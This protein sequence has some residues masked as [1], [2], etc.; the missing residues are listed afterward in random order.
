MAHGHDV[1]TYQ[2]PYG[3][4]EDHRRTT[5]CLACAER[6]EM[7]HGGYT[8][9]T[10]LRRG[11]CQRQIEADPDHAADLAE[12]QAQY[13]DLLDAGLLGERSDQWTE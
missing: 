1:I 8:V 4:G 7:D 5:L 13:Q 10:G 3:G 9:Q 6:E 2:G 11:T 12:E